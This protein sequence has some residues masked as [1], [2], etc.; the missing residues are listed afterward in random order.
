MFKTG[1]NTTKIKVD[2]LSYVIIFSI[3]SYVITYTLNEE[4]YKICFVA[5]WWFLELL[6][7]L[8]GAS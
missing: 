2:I 3:L 4:Y 1:V 7:K 5:T 6:E 8:V